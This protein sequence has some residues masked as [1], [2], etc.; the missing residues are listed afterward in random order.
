MS[1]QHSASLR[2]NK[3]PGLVSK[4]EFEGIMSLIFCRV[5]R[6]HLLK[7]RGSDGYEAFREQETDELATL[8]QDRIRV[9][10]NPK[11]CDK[12]KKLVCTLNKGTHRRAI[13][14]VLSLMSQF[15][16]LATN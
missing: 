10:Q 12:A 11:D 13:A 4:A 3:N 6:A 9:F 16:D 15:Y 14:Q 7:L 5:L 1:L 2:H 8:I